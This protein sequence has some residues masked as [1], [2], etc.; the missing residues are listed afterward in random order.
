MR[1]IHFA[2]FIWAVVTGKSFCWLNAA[3][4][5]R[6]GNDLDDAS[7]LKWG[8]WATATVSKG[9][10][11]EADRKG[12]D[13]DEVLVMHSVVALARLALR[14]GGT[15]MTATVDGITFKGEALG[16]WRVII[17]RVPGEVLGEEEA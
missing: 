7:F 3:D 9:W 11:K 4:S 5:A 16:D 15:R 2:K 8:R 17:E 10:E 12:R 1:P 14:S 13:F 6:A